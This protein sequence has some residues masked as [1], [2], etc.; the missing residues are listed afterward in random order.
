MI[1]VEIHEIQH[2]IRNPQKL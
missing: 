2:K 1:N